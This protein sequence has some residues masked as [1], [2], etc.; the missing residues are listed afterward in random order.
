MMS[1]L[2]RSPVLWSENSLVA[3]TSQGRRDGELSAMTRIP[4]PIPSRSINN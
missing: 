3:Q 1:R 2:C 4:S